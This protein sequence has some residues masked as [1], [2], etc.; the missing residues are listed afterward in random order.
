VTHDDQTSIPRPKVWNATSLANV[1]A[2][3]WLAKGRL[4][5]ASVTI[6]VGDEGIGKSLLWVWIVAA[7]TAG[8]ALPEFGIP[9]RPAGHVLLVLTEDDWSSTVRPRLEL[10]GADL[11]NIAVICE[12]KDGSGTPVFPRDMYL[13]RDVD[14]LDMIVL[15]AFLDT[16]E[17]GLSMRDPQQARQALHPWR[18]TALATGAS[19]LLVTH[20]NRLDS[21]N[22]RDKYGI[23]GELRKKARM[24]LY[25]QRD[26][27][28]RLVVG[29]EKSNI[30][31]RTPASMFTIE[32][33]QV[34]PP[35]DDT[36][37]TVPRLRYLG[38]SEKTAR[39]IVAELSDS[40]H[41]DEEEA[42]SR[43]DAKVWLEAFLDGPGGVLATDVR[44]AST[45]ALACSWSTVQRAARDLGV[46]MTRTGNPPTPVWRLEGR[47]P[48]GQEGMS[49]D[50]VTSGAE[51]G[52]SPQVSHERS[53]EV[54]ETGVTS[55]DLP[56]VTSANTPPDG[57]RGH[58][59]SDT[60]ILTSRRVQSVVVDL[61]ARRET[62]DLPSSA[63]ASTPPRRSSPRIPPKWA[64]PQWGTVYLG[65]DGKA[66][67]LERFSEWRLAGQPDIPV[68]DDLDAVGQ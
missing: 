67:P 51:V 48:R 3:K 45:K 36:D 42:S 35:T 2:V 47:G 56:D 21:K 17:A 1:Q 65:R 8:R 43:E 49:Q 23:S 60:E 39:E 4:P 59:R 40:Q 20:T 61:D 6:L 50:D 41:A 33:V 58:D 18:E 64:D 30:A 53:P 27:E 37:G 22:P 34:F 26:E 54:R 28:D 62:H 16:V 66:E 29:P 52:A 19:V 63:P 5:R 68:P 44:K 15:D 38:D 46:V 10:A 11:A 9:A 25:A 12:E 13:V 32:P 55:R 7:V 31:G 57:P 24:T 14:A